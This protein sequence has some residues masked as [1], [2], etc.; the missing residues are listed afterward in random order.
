MVFFFGQTNILKTLSSFFGRER[1]RGHGFL[2]QVFSGLKGHLPV[3]DF[4]WNKR[5]EKVCKEQ[6]D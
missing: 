4:F 5:I 2:V 1:R 6:I 3:T